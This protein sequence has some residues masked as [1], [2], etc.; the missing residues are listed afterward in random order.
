MSNTLSH[1]RHQSYHMVIIMYL[2]A[3]INGNVCYHRVCVCVCWLWFNSHPLSYHPYSY[4]TTYISRIASL[5]HVLC[6]IIPLPF[7]HLPFHIIISQS[8]QYQINIILANRIHYSSA[9]Q[10]LFLSING[11]IITISAISVP[12]YIARVPHPRY[13]FSDL[14][15]FGVGYDVS[16]WAGCWYQWRCWWWSQP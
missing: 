16:R 13:T 12:I 7:L 10:H 15:L 11:S 14:R 2:Y 3:Q 8:H 5:Y 6:F 1:P 4:N 9:R